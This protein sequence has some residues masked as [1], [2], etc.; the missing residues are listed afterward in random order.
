MWTFKLVGARLTALVMLA[1][2][3]APVVVFAQARPTTY[4]VTIT[5]LT[6]KQVFSPPLLATHAAAMHIWQEGGMASEGVRIVA[7]QGNNTKLAAEL[8]GK[9]TD[10]Q[11]L[12]MN[13]MVMPGKS[14]TVN[15]KANEG[16][17]LSAAF[18]LVQTNDGFT[19]L[20]N[21]ELTGMSVTKET[22]AYDAGTEENT[23]K[24]SDVPGPPFMGMNRV[25]TNPQQPISV[26]Q[27]ITGKADVG[28]DFDWNG[29]AA[30]ITI[31]PVAG[32]AAMPT[33]MPNTGSESNSNVAVLLASLVL[34]FIGS[35]VHRLAKLRR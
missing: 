29:P 2:L 22:M 13:Q 23:E 17:V 4:Q 12:G 20:D 14:V 21:Q 28:S 27:G 11:A 32:D 1:L 34:L 10:M 19:G 9:V 35:G 7:E 33:T 6:D 18:M 8:Q 25:P 5:N 30:R 15:I 31:K 24:A 16:D 3:T 26:H